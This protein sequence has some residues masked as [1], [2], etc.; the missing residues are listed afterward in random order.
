MRA[1]LTIWIL[2]SVAKSTAQVPDRWE[3]WASAGRRQLLDIAPGPTPLLGQPL[4]SFVDE[5]S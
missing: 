3:Q 4:N 2:A 1:V 5:A